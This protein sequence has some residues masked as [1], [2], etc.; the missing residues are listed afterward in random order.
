MACWKII[1]SPTGG[2][3]RVTDVLCGELADVWE[4]IDLMDREISERK[5]A[6]TSD[7]ICV[8]S[9]P[10]YAGRVPLAAS[11]RIASMT[12]DRTRAV[13]V[14]V[15]G[16]RNYDDAL[17]ELKDLLDAAGFVCVAA[18][19]AIA[20]HSILRRYAV[21]RPDEADQAV[22]KEYAAQIAARLKEETPASVLVP[23]DRPYRPAGIGGINPYGDENCIACGLCA[24]RCPVGAI[25][26][27]V[28]T[29]TDEKTC[30]SCM[31]CVAVCP[32]K[33]RYVPASVLAVW[34]ERLGK[35]C[36]GR[37]ENELFL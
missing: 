28:P 9:V 1:F 2:T 14:C 17:V 18:V 7:D 6:F 24:E 35:V 36:R 33:A 15:Y 31:A 3:E 37:K 23:G 4:K 21:G 20:E 26:A 29:D 19:A 16:N 11:Q 22:L 10:V 25:G 8:V 5:Y 27:S 13:L 32:V 30:I 34:D 12:G